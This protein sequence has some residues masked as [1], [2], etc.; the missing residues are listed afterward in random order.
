MVQ[1]YVFD[2]AILSKGRLPEDGKPGGGS[3][4]YVV[5]TISFCALELKQTSVS[6]VFQT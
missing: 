2:T 6:L 4:F 5:F 3:N 1:A